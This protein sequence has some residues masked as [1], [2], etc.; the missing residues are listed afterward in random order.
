[1]SRGTLCASSLGRRRM[2]WALWFATAVA[3]PLLTFPWWSKF[4]L[5]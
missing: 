1:V 5:G 2:R 3:T 4:V